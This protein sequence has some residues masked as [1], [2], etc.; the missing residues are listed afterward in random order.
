MNN[1][2][3]QLPNPLMSEIKNSIALQNNPSS[4]S[5]SPDSENIYKKKWS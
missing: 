5:L 1:G 2:L 4:R 3:A